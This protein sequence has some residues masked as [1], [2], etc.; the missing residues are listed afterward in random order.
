VV[1]IAFAS[2]LLV[3]AGLSAKTFATLHGIYPGYERE[4]LLAF[5]LFLPEVKYPNRIQIDAFCNEAV[6]RIAR[7]PGITSV[8]AVSNGPLATSGPRLGFWSEG[9]HLPLPSEA[10]VAYCV[11]VGPAYFRTLGIPLLEGRDFNDDGAGGP[12]VAIISRS[13]AESISPRE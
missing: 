8:A 7:M 11:S 10:P 13:M 9:S 5:R 4:N 6:S 1:Q 3:A 12:V 2:I